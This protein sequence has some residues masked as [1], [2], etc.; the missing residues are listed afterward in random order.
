MQV[1]S[2]SSNFK[3]EQFDESDNVTEKKSIKNVP[4][5]F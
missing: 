5:N 3:I 4:E 2:H 1:K